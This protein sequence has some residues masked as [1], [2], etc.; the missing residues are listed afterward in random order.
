M[1]TALS[2]SLCDG[3]REFNA[4]HHPAAVSR[5]CFP[6]Y[7]TMTLVTPHSPQPL[8]SQENDKNPFFPPPTKAQ[9]HTKTIEKANNANE[10]SKYPNDPTN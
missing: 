2:A 5:P 6:H 3:V 4:E 10:S 7:S 8:V 1:Q 9:K